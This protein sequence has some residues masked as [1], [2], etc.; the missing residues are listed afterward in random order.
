MLRPE[1]KK[2]V[3]RLLGLVESVEHLI[4][5]AQALARDMQFQEAK[6]V[7]QEV[8]EAVDSVT[9]SVLK[10]A[11]LGVDNVTGYAALVF[12]REVEIFK[13]AITTRNSADLVDHMDQRVIP[14]FD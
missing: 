9:Q 12:C 14:A 11:I 1:I 8:Q 5:R 13:N 6:D 3:D 4:I 10:K 2:I 7:L